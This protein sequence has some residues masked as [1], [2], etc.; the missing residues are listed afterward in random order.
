MR[1]S[2]LSVLLL[3]LSSTAAADTYVVDQSGGSGTDF[4][5]LP[6]A[7]AAPGVMNGDTLL[8]RLGNY[9]GFSTDEGLS[10]VERGN[11]ATVN[12]PVVIHYLAP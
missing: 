7:V 5:D 12:G 4:L 2:I 10:I 8:V 9:S 11:A 3:A 1:T 6:E